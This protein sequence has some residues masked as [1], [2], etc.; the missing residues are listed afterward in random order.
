MVLL[1]V[2]VVVLVLV[3]WDLRDLYL[4]QLSHCLVDVASRYFGYVS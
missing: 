1:S 4:V 2:V 3:A